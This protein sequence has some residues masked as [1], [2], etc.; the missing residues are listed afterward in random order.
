MSAQRWAVL[1]AEDCA[2]LSEPTD[3]WYAAE[4]CRRWMQRDT[5]DKLIVG[6]VPPIE[7]EDSDFSQI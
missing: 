1:R 5:D 3:D 6:L 2:Q 4:E 7:I